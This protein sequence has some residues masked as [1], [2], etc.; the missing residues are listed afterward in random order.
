VKIM[1]VVACDGAPLATEKRLRA[2]FEYCAQL[3][4]VALGRVAERNRPERR[5]DAV[6]RG[7]RSSDG[8]AIHDRADLDRRVADAELEKRGGR[9]LREHTQDK[10]R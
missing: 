4:Q 3:A 10:E 7:R 5:R 6:A 9:L 1:F 8:L 2:T